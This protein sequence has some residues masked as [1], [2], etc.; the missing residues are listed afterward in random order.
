M[1]L[2]LLN[3]PEKPIVVYLSKVEPLINL[4]ILVT[5]VTKDFHRADRIQSTRRPTNT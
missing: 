2:T 4:V 1:G 3:L 5:V